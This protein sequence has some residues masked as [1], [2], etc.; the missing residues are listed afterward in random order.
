[1]TPRT[2]W[3]KTVWSFIVAGLLVGLLPAGA[4]AGDLPL[5]WD[6]NAEADLSGYKVHIGTSSRTYVQTIDVGHVTAFTVSNLSEGQTYFAAVTA[7][8]IFGN[9]SGFSNEVSAATNAINT[10]PS[11]SF[12]FACSD[13]TCTFTSTSIDADGGVVAW[14]WDLG[15]GTSLTAQHPTH[16]YAS[17]GTYAV[18]LTV[19]D[20]AGASDT[21]SQNVTVTSSN[22][23]DTITLSAVGHKEKRFR[24]VE[25]RWDGS[26]S[27]SVDIYRDGSKIATATNQ[28]SFTDS[29]NDAGGG[30][31]GKKGWGGS[32]L[33]RVCEE[34]TSTC[35]NE[36]TVVTFN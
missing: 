11:A 15:E 4:I 18:T 2:G 3:G 12:T 21:T 5:T 31:K 34:G 16:T 19:T 22:P 27:A 9:E 17:E 23:G 36:A 10:P 24:W 35:S 13:L 7:Y 14:T 25:L 6:P 30:K 20:D 33:Y 1:M 29:I 32:Y 8:D 26:T 28:G